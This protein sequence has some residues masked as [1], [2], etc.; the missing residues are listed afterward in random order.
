MALRKLEDTLK[1]LDKHLAEMDDA[2]FFA[3]LGTSI[4]ELREK[5]RLQAETD[6]EQ[7]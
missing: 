3:C 2:T 7:E 5:A 4:E 1:N 6:S